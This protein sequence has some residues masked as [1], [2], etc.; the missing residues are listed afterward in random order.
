MGSA[1][2]PAQS[3]AFASDLVP[4]VN[5]RES[6]THGRKDLFLSQNAELLTQVFVPS[7]DQPV[8][9]KIPTGCILRHRVKCIFGAFERQR[10]LPISNY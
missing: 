8:P 9:D 2:I 5:C 10:H 4:E 3:H 6:H 1:A 7:K